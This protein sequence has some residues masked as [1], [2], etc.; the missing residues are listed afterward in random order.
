[1]SV[2]IKTSRKKCFRYG[3]EIGWS[4]VLILDGNSKIGVHGSRQMCLI[5]KKKFPFMIPFVL[6]KCLEQ[7]K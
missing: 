6:K 3:G 1:M 5:G 7:I 2:H 4:M